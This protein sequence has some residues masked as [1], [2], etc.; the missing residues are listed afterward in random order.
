MNINKSGMLILSASLLLV[1]QSCGN[2]GSPASGATSATTTQ[3]IAPKP[4]EPETPKCDTSKNDQSPINIVTDSAQGSPRLI[5]IDLHC[6]E[7]KVRTAG[8]RHCTDTNT[9]VYSLSLDNPNRVKYNGLEYKFLKF[10]FHDT[11]EHAINMTGAP[12]EMHVVFKN[13]KENLLL[14]IGVMLR[15]A[16]KPEPFIPRILEK[17][18]TVNDTF[19]FN[20]ANLGLTPAKLSCYYTY[21]GSLTTCDYRT[22]VTWFVLNDSLPI[23][24]DL[25]AQFRAMHIC[26]ARCLQPLKGRKVMKAGRCK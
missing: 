11:S 19:A 24:P 7:I 22:G 6:A 26:E 3:A 17:M 1:M 14:V 10:H 21:P 23:T 16:D 12:M 9:E 15:I 4:A 25:V 5:P 18:K 2:N 13:E 20:L 8:E